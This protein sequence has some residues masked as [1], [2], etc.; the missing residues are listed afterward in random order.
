MLARGLVFVAV[1]S[2]A[3]APVGCGPAILDV[4]KDVSVSGSEPAKMIDLSA[5]SQAQKI[6]VEFTSNGSEVSVLLVKEEDA[7][8]SEAPVDVSASKALGS[9]MKSKGDTFSANV[10]PKTATRVIVRFEG[11]KADVSVKLSNRK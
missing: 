2:T 7:R 5:Q 10:P 3:F 4:A 1:V 6:T 11:K 8:G 9:S